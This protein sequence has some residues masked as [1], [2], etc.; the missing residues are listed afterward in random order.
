VEFDAS[1]DDLRDIKVVE[2]AVLESCSANAFENFGVDFD[3]ES[4]EFLLDIAE[5]I[6]SQIS[7]RIQRDQILF[8]FDV[9]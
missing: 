1:L 2:V 5:D 7:L 6:E 4:F 3:R 9:L 8:I